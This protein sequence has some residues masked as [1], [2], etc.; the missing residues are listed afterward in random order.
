MS[1]LNTFKRKLIGGIW[2]KNINENHFK[3]CTDSKNGWLSYFNPKEKVYSGFGRTNVGIEILEDYGS[4]TSFGKFLGY[5]DNSPIIRKF[6]LSS[7]V[8]KNEITM[9]A[10]FLIIILQFSLLEQYS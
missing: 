10:L 1:N 7:F 6:S 3:Y 5:S 2:F 4:I 8:D 9:W